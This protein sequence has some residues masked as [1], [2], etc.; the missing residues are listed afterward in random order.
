MSK[1]EEQLEKILQLYSVLYKQPEEMF[2]IGFIMAHGGELYFHQTVEHDLKLLEH[3][4]E[5]WLPIIQD[6]YAMHKR[7]CLDDI[8]TAKNLLRRLLTD[9]GADIPKWLQ[10]AETL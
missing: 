9:R 5:F 8:K 7:A 2:L 4:A 1:Q 6:Q 10:E 3:N